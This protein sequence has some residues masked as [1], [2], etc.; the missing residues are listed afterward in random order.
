MTLPIVPR[1]C[2]PRLLPILDAR[3]T[4]RSWPYL[5]CRSILR[6]VSRKADTVPESRKLYGFSGLFALCSLRSGAI[7]VPSTA[8]LTHRTAG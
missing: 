4:G 3:S 8:S 2:F 1:Y 5:A 6:L 7:V